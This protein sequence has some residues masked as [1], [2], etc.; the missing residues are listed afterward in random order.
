MKQKKQKTEN[1]DYA[2]SAEMYMDTE[3]EKRRK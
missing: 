1:D 2:M 3:E